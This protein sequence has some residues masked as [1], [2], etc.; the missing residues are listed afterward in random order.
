MAVFQLEENEI[1]F[2]KPDLGEEDGLLAIGGDLSVDR[3]L[4]AYSNGIFPWYNADTPIMWWCPMERFIIKPKDI[5]ISKSLNKYMRQHNTHLL[6]NRDFSDTMHR[7]RM[8]RENEEGGTW[9]HDDM[10]IAYKR[11]YNLGYALSVESF[12]DNRLAGGLYGVVFGKCFFGE[13]MFTDIT[14]GSKIALIGLASLLQ[15][16]DFVFIDC[17]FHTDHLES[18]GGI[19]ISYSEYMNLLRSGIMND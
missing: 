2:P 19:R 6:F 15:D 16:N 11:L 7:C 12:V 13:S 5:H 9:I 14:N 8:K 18:M 1:Y 10:E 3:L 17:Q 4:L